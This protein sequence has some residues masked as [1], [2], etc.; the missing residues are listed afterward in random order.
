[1]KF[2]QMAFWSESGTRFHIEM[3]DLE[4]ETGVDEKDQNPIGQT[5]LSKDKPYSVKK[6]LGY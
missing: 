1:M 2:Q 4:S 6:C 3:P 5:I